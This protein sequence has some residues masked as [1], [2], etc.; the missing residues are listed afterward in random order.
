MVA[1]RRISSKYLLNLKQKKIVCMG[2]VM[3]LFTACGNLYIKQWMLC[4]ADEFCKV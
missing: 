4:V 1:K 3:V 2:F